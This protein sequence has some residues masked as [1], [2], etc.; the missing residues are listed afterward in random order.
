MGD[1]ITDTTGKVIM[2]RVDEVLKE[3]QLKWADLARMT[4]FTPLRISRWVKG[5]GVPDVIQAIKIATA[6]RVPLLW[7][8]GHDV[9]RDTF[10]A[11]N[12]DERGILLMARELGYD[13]TVT[14]LAKALRG[15]S[16]GRAD[17]AGRRADSSEGV[18]S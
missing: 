14:V 17:A 3:R 16:E 7:L 11:L 9:S 13:Q 10:E 15:S 18:A 12:N 4:G 5:Q 1:K 6:L 2:D 8:A